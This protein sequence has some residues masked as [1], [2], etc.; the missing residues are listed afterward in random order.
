[1]STI[2]HESDTRTEA[3]ERAHRFVK[4][5]VHVIRDPSLSDAATRFYGEVASYAWEALDSECYASQ[6]TLARD[7]GW[8]VDKVQRAARECQRRG[9]I[10]C[11]RDGRTNHYRPL[12]D[13][14]NAATD[15]APTRQQIPH[16]CGNRYR[17][18][19]VQ[20]RRREEDEE[21]KTPTEPL[22]TEILSSSRSTAETTT[23]T[24]SH[25]EADAANLLETY[26]E[27]IEYETG[28][29]PV[30]REGDMEPPRGWSPAEW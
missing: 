13:R 22:R 7:L 14:A 30:R 19:E 17:T 29:R 2:H 9:L 6:A 21:K 11:R 16:E 12:N 5:P 1:M 23:T 28:R 15:T 4:V 20:S 24:M 10:T 3:P 8:S 25:S 27:A 26:D 18:G